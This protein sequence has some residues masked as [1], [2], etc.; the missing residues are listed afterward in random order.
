MAWILDLTGISGVYAT[1]LLAEEGHEVI[2]IETPF[3]DADVILDRIASWAKEFPRLQMVSEAQSRRIPSAPV[4]TSL[5]LATDAQL[6]D[7][8]FLVEK[9]DPDFG[10]TR[11]PRGAI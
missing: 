10:M 5:E 1:R 8:G 3:G 2:R 6:I 4:S 11:F 7:R 9:E